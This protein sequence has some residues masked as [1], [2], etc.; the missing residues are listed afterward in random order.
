MPTKKEIRSACE[1]IQCGW[2]DHDREQRRVGNS[3]EPPVI[4]DDAEIPDE[5][6]TQWC[7]LS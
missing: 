4:A 7:D 1:K 3:S 2:T 6:N 5:L